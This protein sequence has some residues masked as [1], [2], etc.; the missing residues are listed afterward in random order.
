MTDD[1]PPVE[2]P[3]LG[4][5]ANRGLVLR[6]G[7]TVRRPRRATSPA[8]AALLQHLEQVGFDGAPRY[9]GE[10]ASG[11]DVLSYVPGRAATLP[12][13]DW[14]LTDEVLDSVAALLRRYHDAVASFDHAPHTWPA[15]PP[16]RF[17]VGEVVSHNDPNLDNVVFR[18]GVAVALIDF[19]LASPGSRLWDVAGAA[20]LWAPLRADGDVDD[21]RRGRTLARLERVVRA[22]GLDVDPH[23]VVAAVRANHEWLYG[24]VASEAES[25]N[26]GLGDYWRHGAADRAERTRAWYA[27]H[28]DA[29]V[30]ALG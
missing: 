27:E 28:A 4:G 9:L 25:G 18:D 3:L 7:D 13:P 24:I 17:G 19:D 2:V 30:A 26:P 8:T 10:D 6:V 1:V 22:Y 23:E 29:L 11:R 15:S 12:Y 20:R 16:R 21:A 5:Y 14:A